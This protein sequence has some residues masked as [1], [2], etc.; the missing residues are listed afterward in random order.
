MNGVDAASPR[1]VPY[2]QRITEFLFDELQRAT[3]PGRAAPL[4][5]SRFIAD[6]AAQFPHR[7]FT[8]NRRK[9]PQHQ[10]PMQP[11]KLHSDVSWQQGRDI[12]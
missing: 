12:T 11:Q 6:V 9:Q 3:Q 5:V 8:V 2:G 10:G 4:R 1:D 7:N